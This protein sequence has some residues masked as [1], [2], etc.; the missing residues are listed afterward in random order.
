M[1]STSTLLSRKLL[2]TAQHAG[3]WDNKSKG[4]WFA[5]F[6]P[7]W[8]ARNPVGFLYWARTCWNAAISFCVLISGHW[9]FVC[10]GQQKNTVSCQ[11]SL[12]L[13][14]LLLVHNVPVRPLWHGQYELSRTTELQQ[15]SHSCSRFLQD[16]LIFLSLLS[17]TRQ[18][19][20][21]KRSHTH[22]IIRKESFSELDSLTSSEA[23]DEDKNSFLICFLLLYLPIFFWYSCCSVLFIMASFFLIL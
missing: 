8:E 13:S 2:R 1:C 7:L 14:I 4:S 19:F 23:R 20:L 15:K 21:S 9:A 16:V 10:S 5:S 12:V 6:C 18:L 3:L 22:T 17:L 11:C